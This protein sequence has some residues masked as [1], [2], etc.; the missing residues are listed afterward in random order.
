MPRLET[1]L[2]KVLYSAATGVLEPTDLAWRS[3]A[4]VNVVLAADGYPTLP[5]SGDLI[6][7]PAPEN[8]TVIV[9][10][11]GTA[12]SDDGLVT[13]GGRILNVVG[14]GTTRQDARAAAYAQAGRITFAGKQFRT[15]IGA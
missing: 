1:D 15:D 10:H 6:T 8:D 9:F 4:A 3:T 11:A 2:L 7:M 5:R 13:R 14:L 12:E